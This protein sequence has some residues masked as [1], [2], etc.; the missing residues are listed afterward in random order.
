[1]VVVTGSAGL[2]S[3]L[4]RGWPARKTIIPFLLLPSPMQ[5]A[6]SSQPASAHRSEHT[7]DSSRNTQFLEGSVF[8]DSPPC[9]GNLLSD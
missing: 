6:H 7:G 4:Q 9:H 8:G 5:E 3:A 1:M 2:L